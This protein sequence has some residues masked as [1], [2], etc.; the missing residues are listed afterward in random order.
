M[1]VD[2]DYEHISGAGSRL[3]LAC[4]KVANRIFG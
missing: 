3:L 2:F 4:K 1:G